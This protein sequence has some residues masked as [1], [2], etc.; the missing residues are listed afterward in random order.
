M[1]FYEPSVLFDFGYPT[2][3]G[4]LDDPHAGFVFHDYCLQSFSAE[5]PPSCHSEKVGVVRA[6]VHVK[7]T[8]EALLLTEFGATSSEAD[9][10]GMV[11]L[12]SRRI[13]WLEWDYS[14]LVHDPSQPPTGANLGQARINALVEPYPQVIAGTPLGWGFDRASRNFQL[15]YSTARAGNGRRFPAGSV[16]EIAAPALIYPAGYAVHAEGAATLSAP[17]A[18]VLELASAPGAHRVIVTIGPAP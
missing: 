13:P 15:T 9:L 7:Q 18:A 4:A 11:A 12:T 2:S 6:L 16:T 14:S 17:G 1:I 10:A 8:R 5:L 3:V